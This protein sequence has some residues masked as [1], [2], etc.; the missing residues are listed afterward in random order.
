M[1]IR[2]H[3]GVF[4]RNPTFGNVRVS[5][6]LTGLSD[7]S[8]SGNLIV[9]AGK[10]VD[11]SATTGTGSSE[12]FDDYETGTWTP[13][14]A[15]DATGT[16]A[17]GNIGF[18]TKVGRLVHVQAQFSVSVN[19]TTNQIGGLPYQ[20]YIES[21]LSMYYGIHP[22]QT[23]GVTAFSSVTDTGT[24]IY[25]FTNHIGTAHNLSTT[26]GLYRTVFSYLTAA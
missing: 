19:F 16:L 7:L 1:T 12:L 11:F 15:G 22:V 8:I 21:T 24:N 4:G 10:G 26:G 5:G 18:Y 14:N 13:T 25:F 23:T 20:P 3:G 2:Q 6:S 9:A 17:A